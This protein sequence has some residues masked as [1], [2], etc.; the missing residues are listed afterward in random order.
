MCDV[1]FLVPQSHRSHESLHL[2]WFP[3]EALSN[4]GRLRHHSLPCLLFALPRPHHL[5]HFVLRDP[6]YFRQWHR[7]LRSLVLPLL[8]DRCRQSLCILLALAIEQICWQCAFGNCCRVFLLDVPL[9]VCLECLLQLH[10][11][12]MTLGVQN[13]GLQ[14]ESFLCNSGQLMR[15]ASLALASRE[16]ISELSSTI[17]L[18]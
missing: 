8:L 10:L 2:H 4:E 9:V 1:G 13:L 14:A 16:K 3:S 7:K 6:S 12:G 15:F 11:L 17:S 18:E 5:E